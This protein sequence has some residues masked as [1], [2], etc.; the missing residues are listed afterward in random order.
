MAPVQQ[1]GGNYGAQVNRGWGFSSGWST[2]FWIRLI[3]AAA[4]IS[5]SLIGACIN[6]IANN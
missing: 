2:F 1:F 6:A 5:L 3:I 4:F